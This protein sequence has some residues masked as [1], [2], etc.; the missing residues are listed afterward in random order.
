MS[1]Q[2]IITVQIPDST[3][4]AGAEELKDDLLEAVQD[5]LI[6]TPN[7]FEYISG[8]IEVKK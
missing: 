2:I 3:P 1:C 6:P 7:R 4:A 5:V 8:D